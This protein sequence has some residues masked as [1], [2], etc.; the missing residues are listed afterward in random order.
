MSRGLG[1]LRVPILS[2]ATELFYEAHGRPKLLSARE[3]VGSGG[4]FSFEQ[5]ESC[6]TFCG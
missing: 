6:E 2:V 4:F 3:P 1:I 5:E